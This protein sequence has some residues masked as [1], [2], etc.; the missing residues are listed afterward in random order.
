MASYDTHFLNSRVITATG[1]QCG[2][3]V[4]AYNRGMTAS[5]SELIKLIEHL[6]DDQVEAVLADVRRIA[7]D[8]SRGAWPPKFFGIG[9]SDDG[10]TDNA[11]RIDEILAEGFVPL[12]L[13]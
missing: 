13:Q 10:R 8:T 3:A 12:T 9:E 4:A 7:A 1:R 5:R 2:L 11:R 6:P